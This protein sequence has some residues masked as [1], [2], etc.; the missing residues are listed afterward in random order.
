M[1]NTNQPSTSSPSADSKQPAAVQNRLLTGQTYLESLRDGRNIWF[2]GERI[3]DITTHRA[4]RNAT[5]TIAHLYDA[6]HDAASQAV[7]TTIEPDGYRVHKFFKPSFSAQELSAARDA[8]AYWQRLTYGWMGRTPDYKAAFMATLAVGSEYYDPFH[9]HAWQW[10]HRFASQALYLNHTLVDP[11]VDRN[12][13][14]NEVRDVYLHVTREDDKGIYVSGAKM[15][16]TGSVLT[17]ATFVAPNSGTAARLQ[18]G[19]DEAFA[20]IF[21]ADMDTP[22]LQLICRPSYE[23]NARS[24]FDA[25]LSS[26]F[27]ENDS[28][29]IFDRAFIPWENVLVYRDVPKVQAFYPQSGFFNRYNLH[30]ATR[31]AIKLGFI[32]GLLLKGTAASGTDTFRG[33]QAHAGELIAIR[34]LVW[35]LT[36]AMVADPEPSLGGSVVPNLETAAATRIY[37]AGIWQRVREIFEVALAGSPIVTVSSYRDLQTPALEPLIDRYMRGTGLNAQERLKL[38][39]LIW[40]ALYSEFAGRHA[41]YERNY[42]GNSDQQRLDALNFAR[43]RG[44]AEA[45]T[46]L[47]DDCLQEYDLG[48]W[49]VDYLKR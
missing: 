18:A 7:L 37:M 12:R 29:I 40:D 11:P 21:I 27:D 17:H 38:F 35:S 3:Q 19:R 13:P 9:E 49:Q 8:I 14:Y 4:F 45:F 44:Q 2:D 10:Y 39:K 16:A 43:R 42:A 30:A 6:L 47:V 36:T 46:R 1:T 24:P 33:V 25:P 32:C 26:R 20:V 23:Y 41:L 48:G 5:L 34:N 28:L 15:V 31:L 22:G